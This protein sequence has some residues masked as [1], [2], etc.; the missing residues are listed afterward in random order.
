MVD[1]KV[2][3]LAAMKL[4]WGD[5]LRTVFAR[6][7][8]YARDPRVPATQPAPDMSVD[9]MGDLLDKIDAL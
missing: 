9:S 2:W 5:R 7:G 1:D 6:Q 3:I 4:V 8:H